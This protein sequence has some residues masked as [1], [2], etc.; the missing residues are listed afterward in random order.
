MNDGPVET[1]IEVE[2]PHLGTQAATRQPHVKIK[3]YHEPASEQLEALWNS[4]PGGSHYSPFQSVEFVHAFRTQI[5]SAE[6]MHFAVLGASLGKALAPDMLL[7]VVTSRRGPCRIASMPDMGLADQN[8]PVMSQRLTGDPQAAR[9]LCRALLRSVPGADL[10]DMS[11]LSPRIGEVENPLYHMQ[12]TI[13]AEGT[14][15]FDADAL[16]DAGST[17]SKSVY[18]EARTKFRKLLKAGVELVEVT[19]PEE[20]QSY[21]E[22]LLKQRAD[23]FAALGRENSLQRP[24]RADFYR[25]LAGSTGLDNPLRIL[26][27]KKDDEIVATTVLMVHNGIANGVLTSMGDPS[28]HRLSP[29]IVLLIQAVN[30]ARD[31]KVTSFNFGTGL[32]N[33]KHRF[34]ANELTNRRLLLPLN[35]KGWVAVKALKAKKRAIE[36]LSNMKEKSGPDL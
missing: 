24:G 30:W 21:L 28:W 22:M 36:I 14:L 1:A 27:L 2:A 25:A 15:V 32:Q 10:V 19:A 16:A 8:A 6:D 7:P 13:E 31:H 18:K 5:A 3:R 29:G 34:G 12:E 33:Y 9:V 26:A 11:K 23:R 35:V 20:R 17:S 4:L